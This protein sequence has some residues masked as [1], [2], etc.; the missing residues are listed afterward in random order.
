MTKRECCPIVDE[1]VKEFN[2]SVLDGRHLR[3]IDQNVRGKGGSLSAA[4]L[5]NALRESGKRINHKCRDAKSF[6]K[7]RGFNSMPAEVFTSA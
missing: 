7:G 2:A 4:R 5:S 3:G 6:L 1:T